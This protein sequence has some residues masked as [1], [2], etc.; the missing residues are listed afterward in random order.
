MRLFRLLCTAAVL[1]ALASCAAPAPAAPPQPPDC[2]ND[3]FAHVQSLGE[4]PLGVQQ[5]LGVGAAGVFRGG[6]AEPG[7]PFNST[8]VLMMGLPSRR[9]KQAQVNARCAIV[10]IEQGGIALRRIKLTYVRTNEGWTLAS[11][12]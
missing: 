11:T 12:R 4:L 8:D 7:Q 10:E 5:A 6:I 2:G 9:L 1:A 3:R